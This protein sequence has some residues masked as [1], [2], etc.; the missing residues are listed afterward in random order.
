MELDVT[1]DNFESA[2]VKSDVPVLIDFWADWCMPCKMIE[3][4]VEEL[5]AEY[6]GRLVVGRLNV[7]EQAELAARYDIVSIPSLLMF[8][9]GEVADR[10]VGAAPRET[11]VEFIQNH[12]E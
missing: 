8:K 7:D 4:I 2:V 5:A 12:V 10:H 11:L 1:S 9:D 3:P 6:D